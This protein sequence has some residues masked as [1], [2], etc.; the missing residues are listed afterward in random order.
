MRCA[1]PLDSGH[2]SG[3][4]EET[5]ALVLGGNN[6]TGKA[7]AGALYERIDAAR[8]IYCFEMVSQ[9]VESATREIE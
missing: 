2:G 3:L 4:N 6:F 5:R 9:L 7:C 8:F 1:S